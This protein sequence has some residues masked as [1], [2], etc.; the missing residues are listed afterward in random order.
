MIV[1]PTSEQPPQIAVVIGLVSTE[2]R[3]RILETL[4]SLDELQG[5][6]ACE[7]VLTD[8][9]RDAVSALVRRQFPEVKLIEC[10][11]GAALPEMRA[12]AFEATRAPLVAVTEDHCVP[13]AGWLEAI[14]TAFKDQP[15]EVAAI[16]G[17]VENGVTEAGFDWATY[18]CEYSYFSAPVA[19]GPT[20]II[21]GMNVVYRRSALAAMTREVLV[22]GFWETTVHPL[23]VQQGKTLLSR[24]AIKMHHCKKFSARLFFQQRYIYSRYYAGLRFSRSQV[25][26]RIAAAL[27][28]IALPPLL[29]YR[30]SMAAFRKRLAAQFL[31]A[32]PALAALVVVW[33]LGEIW[34]YMF[35]PGDALVRIE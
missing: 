17:V 26:K 25:A 12:I 4:R 11:A 15:E 30:M 28:S 35:G 1:P 29:F 24:N 32:S 2:D 13:A 14:L 23:L 9:R 6:V 27:A 7:V 18:L 5:E 21:P 10:N 8:R 22:S 34:G 31:R 16:G 3:D 20:H 19:E 33:S